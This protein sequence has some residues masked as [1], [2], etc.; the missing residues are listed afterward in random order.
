MVLSNGFCEMT[1]NEVM[2]VDGGGIITDAIAIT[3]FF[4]GCLV[5]GWN[6]GRNVVRDV[7]KKFFN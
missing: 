1:Q 4:A 2:T 6:A 3:G 7:K 5:S